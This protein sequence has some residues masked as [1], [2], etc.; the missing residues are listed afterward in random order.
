MQ[1][2]FSRERDRRTPQPQTTHTHNTTFA[3]CLLNTE[4]AMCSRNTYNY[5]NTTTFNVRTYE[6]SCLISFKHPKTRYYNMYPWFDTYRTHKVDTFERIFLH[7]TF[8]Y[9][10]NRQHN[11]IHL[12]GLRSVHIILE[13]ISFPA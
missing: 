4:H 2:Q 6:C 1:R 7:T 12:Y 13:F 9:P 3:T 5:S 8:Y 11:Y 10:H